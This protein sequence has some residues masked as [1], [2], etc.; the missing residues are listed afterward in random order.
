MTPVLKYN[1]YSLFQNLK[2]LYW[3]TKNIMTKFVKAN[4][5]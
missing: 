1:I 5:Q 4:G 2:S 3:L